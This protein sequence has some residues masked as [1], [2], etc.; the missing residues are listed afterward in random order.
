MTTFTPCNTC[1]SATG[2]TH[3]YAPHQPLPDGCATAKCMHCGH[4]PRVLG[5]HQPINR[6]H[7]VPS[8]PPRKP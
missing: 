8:A 3:V 7:G 2:C 6:G 5:G 1:P 4:E